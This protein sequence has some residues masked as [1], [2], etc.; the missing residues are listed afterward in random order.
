MTGWESVVACLYGLDT[1]QN[2]YLDFR[3]SAAFKAERDVS[4]LSWKRCV[5]MQTWYICDAKISH[6]MHLGA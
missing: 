5:N 4:C 3:P 6:Y 2:D 1:D